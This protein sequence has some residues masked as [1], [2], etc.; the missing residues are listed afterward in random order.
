MRYSKIILMVCFLLVGGMFRF[1]AIQSSDEDF[2]WGSTKINAYFDGVDTHAVNNYL[3]V[4]YK[5]NGDK[6]TLA[7]STLSESSLAII[8]EEKVDHYKEM[9]YE[10]EE[11]G[12]YVYVVKLY[13]SNVRQGWNNT[14]FENIGTENHYYS[15]I[16]LARFIEATS[17][18]ESNKNKINTKEELGFTDSDDL[19]FLIPSSN[20]EYRQGFVDTVLYNLLD[21]KNPIDLYRTDRAKLTSIVE[22]YNQA[23]L[24]A[25]KINN[26]AS[27][28]SD[29]EAGLNYKVI[30]ETLV[31]YDKYRHY[32]DYTSDYK[33]YIC[34]KSNT[35]IQINSKEVLAIHD[36]VEAIKTSSTLSNTHNIRNKSVC[37]STI[38]MDS[39]EV[40]DYRDEFI[41]IFGDEYWKSDKLEVK[42][43]YAD[44]V[45]TDI[46]S[47][48]G[49]GG[50]LNVDPN[51]S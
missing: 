35:T 50:R 14:N 32:P 4:T 51:N 20:S 13:T 33:I 12:S 6:Y 38:W 21:G 8:S 31:R 49:T 10:V 23:I 48:T 18:N 47:Y 26:I 30:P 27:S 46:R 39:P 25:M 3:D 19:V 36:M 5:V 44:S 22:V 16:D 42:N 29:G 40:R 34:Y 9:G 45:G 41:Q 43:L 28:N 11:V 37:T 7:K 2:V 17:K 15:K 1:F 24:K